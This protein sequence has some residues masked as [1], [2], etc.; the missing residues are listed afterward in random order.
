[1]AEPARDEPLNISRFPETPREPRVNDS[2][3]LLPETLPDRPLGEWPP[4]MR[5]ALGRR[6]R[7]SAQLDEAGAKVGS[8]LANLVNKTRET[9][10]SVAHQTRE[11]SG[12]VQ[13]RAF[14]LKQRLQVTSRRRAS[15]FKSRAADLT[16]QA[17][18]RASE[19]TERTSKQARDL[20][21]HVDSYAHRKP[22]QFI[23][24]VAASAFLIGFLLRMGRDE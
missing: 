20:Q 14:D 19:L 2:A 6:P 15:E 13:D 22:F 5:Q 10:G 4:E 3:G 7:R 18:D 12:R 9:L 1:M 17:Q 11:T 8:A 23:G 21:T 24:I 16:D